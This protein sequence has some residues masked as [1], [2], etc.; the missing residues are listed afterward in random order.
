M[1]PLSHFGYV[2]EGIKIIQCNSE[3]KIYLNEGLKDIPVKVSRHSLV[4][5]C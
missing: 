2:I 4:S 1:A 3:K 5:L